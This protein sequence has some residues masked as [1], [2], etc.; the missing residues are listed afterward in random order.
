MGREARYTIKAEVE[1]NGV[2]YSS[3][4]RAVRVVAG[5]PLAEKTRSL[6]GQPGVRLT[7]TVRYWSRDQKEYAFLS[8]EDRVNHTNYGVFELGP[9]LRINRPKIKVDYKG[10]V[11]VMHRATPGCIV[12]SRFR[13]S[14]KGLTF[15][16]QRFLAPSGKPFAPD[17]EEAE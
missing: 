7:Y 8:V 2:V 5:M 11:T 13:C 16:E 17:K 14:E 1:R 10:N 15:L 12:R 9:L 4:T 3:P 6:P